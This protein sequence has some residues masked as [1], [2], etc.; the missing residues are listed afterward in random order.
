MSKA[1][2]ARFGKWM[3]E[4]D[5]GDGARTLLYLDSLRAVHAV[6]RD[7]I[8]RFLDAERLDFA[9]ATLLDIA[10]NEGWFTFEM[11]KREP[12]YDNVDRV[13]MVGCR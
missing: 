12:Q 13:V 10:C 8:T 1:E 2:L 4:F 7:M 11:L 9:S 5:Q 6:R 3:Y